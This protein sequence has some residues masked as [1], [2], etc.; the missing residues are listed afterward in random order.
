MEEAKITGAGGHNESNIGNS[1]RLPK[2]FK[3]DRDDQ[4][5]CGVMPLQH[6]TMERRGECDSLGADSVPSIDLRID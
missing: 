5:E 3:D 6:R 4:I 2:P 1:S